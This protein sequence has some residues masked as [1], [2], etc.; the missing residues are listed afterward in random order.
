MENTTNVNNISRLYV[1]CSGYSFHFRHDRWHETNL[2]VIIILYLLTTIFIA[3]TN[4]II[5]RTI[6]GNNRLS[7]PSHLLILTNCICDFGLS[8]LSS[9]IWSTVVILGYMNVVVDCLLFIT[10][11]FILHFF[12]I[13]SFFIVTLI[14][15]DKY[16]GILKPFFYQQH[17]D[18]WKKVYLRIIGCFSIFTIA[19]IVVTLILEVTAILIFGEIVLIISCLMLNIT[20]YVIIY[21]EIKLLKTNYQKRVGSKYESTTS[22]RE[23]KRGAL[24][25]FLFVCSQYVCYSPYVMNSIITATKLYSLDITYAVS[26]WSYQFVL[27]KSL[28]NPILSMISLKT[29][30]AEVFGE[31]TKIGN[32]LRDIHIKK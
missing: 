16:I 27:F 23:Q 7:A 5:I 29:L 26:L 17:I 10:S 30:Q 18:K 15:V 11:I 21:K 20:I 13:M 8:T 32:S 3:T 4:L 28:F 31:R 2:L 25:S 19:L 22:L 1:S 12:A 6:K 14:S 24:T 9:P